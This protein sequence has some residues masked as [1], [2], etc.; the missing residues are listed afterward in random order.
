M[1]H[2]GRDGFHI[3]SCAPHPS[4]GSVPELLV[5]QPSKPAFREAL[6]NCRLIFA[7]VAGGF[8]NTNSPG[9]HRSGRMD[10]RMSFAGPLSGILLT[11][12]CLFSFGAF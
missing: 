5:A 8:G 11:L 9:S 12:D 4:D 1:A 2:I 10:L 7:S 3:N 6:R